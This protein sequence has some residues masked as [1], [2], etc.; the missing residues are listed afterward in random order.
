MSSLV[1]SRR[2]LDFLLFEWLEVQMLAE[3]E[4]FADHS[5]E[6]FSSALDTYEAIALERFAPHNRRND[7]EEPTF[8]DERVQLHDEIAPALEAFAQAGLFAATQDYELEGSQ[9]P[10]VVERAGMAFMFAANVATAAYPFLTMA[11]ANLLLAY[12]RPE[13]QRRYLKPMLK[14]RFFGTMCLSEPQAGSSLADI[15]TRA[16][17]QGDGTYRLFGNKMWISGGEH[18]LSENIVHLV[19]AKIPDATGRLLPGVQGISLFIVPKYLVRDDGSIGERNDVALAGLNHKLGY[20]GTTN[21]LLNFGE[22]RFRI[23]NTGEATPTAGAIGELVGV[24]GQGLA[25]MFHM[26]NEAR[27]GVGVG[28]VALGYTGYL[29]ALEYARTRRQG[30]TARQRDPQRPP[31][32]LIEHPDVR[33]MLL[34]QKSYVEGG[35]ALV[36]YCSRLI[37]EQETA[38]DPKAREQAR[39]LLDLLTPVAKSWPAQ[40]CLE[41]NDLAIQVHGGYGYT[42]D[43]PVEQFWRDNRLNAIH[44]GT[45]G[46]QALDLVGRK[47]QLHD[48]ESFRLFAARLEQTIARAQRMDGL[49][50]QAAYLQQHWQLLKTVTEKLLACPD[51][52]ERVANASAYLEAFGHLVVGMMWLDVAATAQAA[53]TAGNQEH[54]KFYSGKLAACRYFIFWELPRITSMLAVLDPVERT[55]LDMQ[56]D[57]F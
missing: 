43:Y 3:R 53:L 11:N 18:E 32:P 19:L 25:Y 56:P 15:T 1:L 10:Y 42:R 46:I 36:L 49:L 30:R 33:R 34:A 54:A 13:Q 51:A 41:A 24:A 20:R 55:C 37:D 27:I 21:C 48:G 6:T 52:A 29:H 47:L 12:A 57:W 50:S 39:Q 45:H 2:D 38:N 4:R 28:A 5:R 23:A 35:M 14:G 16:L 7:M 44:E 40:W 22:G 31:V 9:L 17:P 8:V 26:M